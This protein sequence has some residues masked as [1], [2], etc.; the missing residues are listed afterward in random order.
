MK[1]LLTNLFM[2]FGAFV[3]GCD[4]NKPSPA[5]DDPESINAIK[6]SYT[7]GADGGQLE[8]QVNSNVTFSV[9]C[10]ESWI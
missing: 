7:I 5:P 6:S 1:K 2:A 4:Q 10:S 8:L 3:V 9:T